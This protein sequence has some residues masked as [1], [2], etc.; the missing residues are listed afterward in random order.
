MSGRALR[1][2]AEARAETRTLGQRGAREELATLAPRSPSAT[3]RPTVNAG[4]L[5]ADEEGSVETRIVRDEHAVAGVG[6][7]RHA[8]SLSLVRLLGWPFSDMAATPADGSASH[9][10]EPRFDRNR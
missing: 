9:R 7:E 6:I 1:A 3:D 10:S 5:D 8:P 4:R 2:A